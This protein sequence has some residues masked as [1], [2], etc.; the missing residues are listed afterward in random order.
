MSAMVDTRHTFTILVVY[1]F[2]SY[3]LFPLTYTVPAEHAQETIS[4]EGTEASGMA[5]A[6]VSLGECLRGRTNA[7]HEK[8]G[9]GGTVSILIKKNRAIVPE[10]ASVKL[11]SLK[12]RSVPIDCHDPVA[13][14][15]YSLSVPAA[16]VPCTYG[17]YISLFTGH[18]PPMPE[19][20]EI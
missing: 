10:N 1:S 15:A 14:A 4:A 7:L 18:S 2:L 16:H 13:P 12:Q 19:I 6:S 9:N 8:T 20:A 3:S 5:N 11:R 17:G